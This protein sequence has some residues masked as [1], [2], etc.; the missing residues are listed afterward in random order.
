[1]DGKIGVWALT[2]IITDIRGEQRGQV[3]D[4][5]QLEAAPS[6]SVNTEKEQS[7]FILKEP[8]LSLN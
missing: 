6:S 5:D 8:V 2:E 1:M 3:T 4:V 7:A